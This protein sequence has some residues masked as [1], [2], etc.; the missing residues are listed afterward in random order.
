M[1]LQ[2]VFVN[3]S[4]MSSNNSSQLPYRQ[5]ANVKRRTWDREAYEA[6]AKQQQDKTNN[7]ASS[8]SSSQQQPPLKRYRTTDPEVDDDEDIKEEFRPAAPNAT[9]AHNSKRALLQ[10]RQHRVSNIDAKVGTVELV[11]AEQVATHK[12]EAVVVDGNAVSHKVRKCCVVS[13]SI[14]FVYFSMAKSN[15]NSRIYLIS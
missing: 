4:L 8:T 2:L 15:L 1:S 13:T 10:P 14:G 7:N 11:S 12:S 9:K 5:A 6:K 3:T